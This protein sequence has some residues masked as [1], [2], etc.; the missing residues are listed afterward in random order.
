MRRKATL[1]VGIEMIQKVYL[2]C[3]VPGSGKTWV[4]EQLKYK[5]DYLPHDEHFENFESAILMKAQKALK[6]VITECPFAERKIRERLEAWGVEVIPVFVVES[7]EVT[8]ARF[9]LRE[10]KPFSKANMTRTSSIVGRAMEWS[11]TYGTSTQ[12]LAYLRGLEF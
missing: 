1:F 6:P 8:R 11:A 9:E 12:I 2:I 5:F 3:G 10:N 4:C 7:A